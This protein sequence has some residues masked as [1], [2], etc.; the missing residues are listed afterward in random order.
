MATV[1]TKVTWS[2]LGAFGAG[3]VIA[4]LNSLVGNSEVLGSFP[5]VLQF[6]FLSAGPFVISFLSGFAKK[7]N[8]SSVSTSHNHHLRDNFNG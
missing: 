1:E 7:S 5:P 6:F 2:A 8:T 3:I 4:L